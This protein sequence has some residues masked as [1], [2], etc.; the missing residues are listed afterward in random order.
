MISIKNLTPHP[1]TII[2]GG[3]R[4]EYPACAPTDLPRATEAMVQPDMCLT[5]GG[6]DGQGGYENSRSLSETGLVDNL[7]YTGVEGLPPFAPGERMFGSTT[8]LIVSVVT[9][10]GAL[11]A[12][13]G[14]EDLL[15]PMGQVRDAS[16]RIVGATSLAPAASLLTP[17]YRA[18]AD[19][20]RQEVINALQERNAARG[21]APTMEQVAEIER[22][23]VAAP[24][25]P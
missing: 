15:I 2:R 6:S 14:V 21:I 5:D 25:P 4:T 10:I 17:L 22:Q 9:A 13:R 11:A 1:V 3:Q 16:G 7:G 19:P 24:C 23:E 18:I 20:Y 12:G 8:F